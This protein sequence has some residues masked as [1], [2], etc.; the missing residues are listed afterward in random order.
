MNKTTTEL[1]YR[2]ILDDNA[3]AMIS[4]LVNVREKSSE[5]ARHLV[6]TAWDRHVARLQNDHPYECET[7]EKAEAILNEALGF[8][9]MLSRSMK[10][11]SPSALVDLGWH[12][13]ML[14]SY[15]YFALCD[16]INGAYIHHVPD[17]LPGEQFP[18]LEDS[19]ERMLRFGPVNNELWPETTGCTGNC[20]S[21]GGGHSC[22]SD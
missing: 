14:D 20:S 10:S 12:S 4:Y 3:G 21:C 1:T 13:L 5:M 18:A 16:V 17:T 19:V 2:K 8:L 11:F 9:W 15:L 6:S 7:K 22:R